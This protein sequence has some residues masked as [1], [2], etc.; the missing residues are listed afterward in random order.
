MGQLTCCG[1][2]CLKC[3]L[4]LFFPVKKEKMNVVTSHE[5][6]HD[7]PHD[8][9]CQVEDGNLAFHHFL[10]SELAS[11]GRFWELTLVILGVYCNIRQPLKIYIKKKQSLTTCYKVPPSALA[12]PLETDGDPPRKH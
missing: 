3:V 7:W 10:T 6:K 4:L 2:L 12:G 9:N 1:C 8:P 5:R 11:R